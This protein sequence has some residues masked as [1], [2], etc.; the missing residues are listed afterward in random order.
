[1]SDD[2]ITAGFSDTI[3]NITIEDLEALLLLSDGLQ[4]DLVRGLLYTRKLYLKMIPC[5][6]AL[7][8]ELEHRV[9]YATV[10]DIREFLNSLR[11]VVNARIGLAGKRVQRV[12]RR[13]RG[14]SRKVK[15]GY[16]RKVKRGYSRKVKRGNGRSGCR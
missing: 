10:C 9:E 6:N 12:R 2:E 3:D 4:K 8:T 5:D 14:Y 16:S 11:D 7:A 13:K 1:M 15:R